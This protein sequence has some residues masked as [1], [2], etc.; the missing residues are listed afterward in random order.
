M[1]SFCLFHW[2]TRW[3]EKNLPWAV[4]T[5]AGEVWASASFCSAWLSCPLPLFFS[6]ALSPRWANCLWTTEEEA[7]GQ[8]MLSSTSWDFGNFL[9][10]WLT[11]IQRF[12]QVIYSAVQKW[13][14]TVTVWILSWWH[15]RAVNIQN[16][17]VVNCVKITGNEKCC[18]R[19]R[20]QI[21]S[22][23]TVQI[24]ISFPSGTSEISVYAA[25]LTSDLLASGKNC[26]NSASRSSCPLKR[27]ATL[28]NTSSSVIPLLPRLPRL[29]FTSSCSF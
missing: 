10:N 8:K 18:F 9:E 19:A 25:Q 29:S 22:V 17:T 16:V 12:W 20:L 2:L 26:P 24:F 15:F 14:F 28:E 21:V 6:A 23:Q 3:R 7:R 13:H 1:H 4:G 5:Y 27:L 11:E